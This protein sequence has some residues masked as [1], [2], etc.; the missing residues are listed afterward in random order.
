MDTE[1]LRE[2][3][4]KLEMPEQMKARIVAGCANKESPTVNT[5]KR[6]P[7]RRSALIAA[8]LAV[9]LCLSAIGAAAAAAGY[10]KDVIRAD[11]TVV[12]AVY[13]Q[14]TDELTLSA[15][16][17]GDRL[18]VTVTML[19]PDKPPYS[20][21]EQLR[22]GGCRIADMSGNVVLENAGTEPAPILD[23]KAE[24]TLPLDGLGSGRYTLTVSGFTGSKKADQPLP[25]SGVWQCEFE[26]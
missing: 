5:T 2:T 4:G 19:F 1:R 6:T 9:V 17:D 16:V 7:V 22:F 18:H 14:A 15:S 24:M 21:C 20:E 26:I 10:F 23:G 11:G 25:I 3:L 12:G 8:A 13:E